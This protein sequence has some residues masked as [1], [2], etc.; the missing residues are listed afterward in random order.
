MDA[1]ELAVSIAHVLDSKKALDI[2]VLDKD[3]N[4]IELSKLG[5]EETPAYQTLEEVEDAVDTLPG[6]DTD[7][8]FGEEDDLMD[9]DY[10]EDTEFA[11]DAGEDLFGEDE[12]E[13]DDSEF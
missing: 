11:D 13:S 4:E 12:S 10:P 3:G 6:E 7:V 8:D 5:E 9:E 1:K 2:R